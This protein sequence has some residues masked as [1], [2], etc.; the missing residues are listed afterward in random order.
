VQ[1]ILA[2][3]RRKGK[4]LRPASAGNAFR[5]RHDTASV[6]TDGPT[7]ASADRSGGRREH[8]RRRFCA[9]F[10]RRSR[11]RDRRGGNDVGRRSRAG[12]DSRDVLS[13]RSPPRTQPVAG[14][15]RTRRDGGSAASAA[16][17][18]PARPRSTF[19][20][21]RQPAPGNGA[22]RSHDCFPPGNAVTRAPRPRRLTAVLYPPRV[23]AAAVAADPGHLE[24][25]I[26]R[27]KAVRVRDFVEP[28]SDL[29]VAELDDPVAA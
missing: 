26:G 19:R 12:R 18:R 28:R 21:G 6:H 8:D 29:T 24:P 17:L 4:G 25:M 20:A 10:G 13:E 7:P 22:A 9:T 11:P 23:L 2:D 15:R 16:A 3:A 27:D 14:P 5:R 1:R